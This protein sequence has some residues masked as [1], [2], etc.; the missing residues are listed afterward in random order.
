MSILFPRITVCFFQLDEH[1]AKYNVFRIYI[2][3]ANP[4]ID[5]DMIR[6]VYSY[7]FGLSIPFSLYARL[8]GDDGS[9]S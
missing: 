2:G 7:T 5:G 6:F 1:F 3:P 4:L 8:R 9:S